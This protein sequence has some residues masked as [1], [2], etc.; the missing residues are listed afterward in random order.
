MRMILL[1][2]FAVTFSG[3]AMKVVRDETPASVETKQIKMKS[4]LWAFIPGSK[5]PPASELCPGASLHALD[6]R[7][8]PAD[9][10]LTVV[11]A[12]VFVPYRVDYSC[13]RT[14]PGQKN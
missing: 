13:T 3:C 10:A 12:G 6:L 7:M 8:E 2:A 14:T 11:T 4:F 5:V 1:A 9:V